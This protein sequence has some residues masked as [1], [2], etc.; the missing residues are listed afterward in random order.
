[1]FCHASQTPDR[2]GLVKGSVVSFLYQS[3]EKGGKA[4]QV[5]IEAAAEENTLPRE[6]RL[7]YLDRRLELLHVSEVQS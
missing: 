4:L 6:V 7:D 3:D 1:M 5:Q 2:K